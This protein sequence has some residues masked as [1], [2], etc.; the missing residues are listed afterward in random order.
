[1]EYST[2]LESVDSQALLSE[3]IGLENG[4]ELHLGAEYVFVETSPLLSVRLGA[5]Y[6]P[7]HRPRFAGDFPGGSREGNL[8][9]AATFPGGAGEVHYAVGLGLA[10]AGYQVD[11]GVDLS[12][13]V[14]T[15][16]VSMIFGF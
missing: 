7:D 13:L 4:H 12:E 16:A 11:I 6:D 1:M 5:W 14:D 3:G 10:F 9:A 8:L 2:I 15:V